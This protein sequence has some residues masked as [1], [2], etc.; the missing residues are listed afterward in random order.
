MNYDDDAVINKTQRSSEAW[1]RRHPPCALYPIYS[2][3]LGKVN[4]QIFKLLVAE[5]TPVVKQ[6]L[7]EVKK[8]A[9]VAIFH[10]RSGSVL[11]NVEH[12]SHIPFYC[13]RKLFLIMKLEPQHIPLYYI[14]GRCTRQKGEDSGAYMSTKWPFQIPADLSS[15]S[16]TGFESMI[17]NN[18]NKYNNESVML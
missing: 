15:P 12:T 7:T 8:R 3:L 2:Y 18:I 6:H 9:K 5:S 11:D 10:T 13:I 14:L 17:L 1:A 16:S 4:S